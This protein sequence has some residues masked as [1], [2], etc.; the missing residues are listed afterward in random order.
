M[1]CGSITDLVVEL[2][3][4]VTI[5]DVN[6]A[7]EA[8]ETLEF[9]LGKE[10]QWHANVRIAISHKCWHAI[11]VDYHGANCGGM[12]GPSLRNRL[13]VRPDLI[14]MNEDGVAVRKQ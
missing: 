12:S 10:V 1:P 8:A 5:E 7:I 2:E 9:H 4:D 14:V 6:G 11:G 13:T 3:K